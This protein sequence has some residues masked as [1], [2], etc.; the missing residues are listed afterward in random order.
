M[1][2]VAFAVFT[3]CSLS[4]CRGLGTPDRKRAGRIRNY[5]RA[6]RPDVTSAPGRCRDSARSKQERADRC[7]PH[8]AG[9]RSQWA[10]AAGREVTPVWM[11]GSGAGA[12]W[13]GVVGGDGGGEAVAGL[14]TVE[15]VAGCV[16]RL[17]EGFQ[18][19]LRSLPREP[20]LAH[21][22]I[23]PSLKPGRPVVGQGFR[24]LVRGA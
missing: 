12:S 17:G 15:P 20:G 14:G 10:A 11:V 2:D 4:G 9:R 21:G 13:G 19:R 23:A 8:P 5:D 22:E 16:Q 6:A 18:G 7:G 3:G 1:L 24:R